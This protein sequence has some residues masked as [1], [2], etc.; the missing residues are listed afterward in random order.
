[1][2]HKK[3]CWADHSRWKSRL[4]IHEDEW[5]F[6]SESLTKRLIRLSRNQFSLKRL[7]EQK[8]KIRE[9][10]CGILEVGYPSLKQVRQVVLEGQGQAWIYARSIILSKGEDL[11]GNLFQAIGNKPLGSVLFQK[12]VFERSKIEITKY[13]REFLPIDYRH[14]DLWARR[15]VFICSSQ[16]VLVQ[17]VFLPDLWKHI[18][19]KKKQVYNNHLL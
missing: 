18:V 7:S 17:E 2:Y 10:E 19:N 5:L 12:D 4:S 3:L 13:P 14:F 9:D 16:S 6:N 1:M 11:R 8:Q 15:S